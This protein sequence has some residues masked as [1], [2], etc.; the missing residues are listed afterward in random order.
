MMHEPTA[1][2]FRVPNEVIELM[3]SLS[4][5]AKDVLFY[6]MRHTWGF[7]NMRG[8]CCLTHEEIKNGRKKNN[9]ERYD[10]GTQLADQSVTNGINEL[11]KKDVIDKKQI[12]FK[13]KFLGHSYRIRTF[14]NSEAPIKNNTAPLKFSELYN[15]KDINNKRHIIFSKENIINKTSGEVLSF[16][17]S[18]N[19]FSNR[20]E[21][22]KKEF[23]KIPEYSKEVLDIFD[24]Y[25]SKGIV[26]H[27]KETKGYYSTLKE[28][29]EKLKKHSTIEI[30]YTIDTY[31]QVYHCPELSKKINKGNKIG[32]GQLLN[33]KY[34]K[35]DW[36]KYFYENT[37]EDLMAQKMESKAMKD[38]HQNLTKEIANKYA[39]KFLGATEYPSLKT[40][41]NRRPDIFNR[42]KIAGD[43]LMEFLKI[44]KRFSDKR[45]VE[46]LVN[47]IA[48]ECENYG[49]EPSPGRLCSNYCWDELIRKYIKDQF[50]S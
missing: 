39:E 6:I 32:L 43:R 31:S 17:S 18:L 47:A 13:D 19:S 28:I 27:S 38:N 50:S 36:F 35:F 2:Y 30:K 24:Y 44:E 11:V 25:N 9:G 29:K 22:I 1:N 37:F 49:F 10:E 8:F 16:S 40:L 33:N 23:R 20:T 26:R 45:M 42:F 12:K 46:I 14:E 41:P 21:A 3:P 15:T 7:N 4:P 48:W 34:G 5:S